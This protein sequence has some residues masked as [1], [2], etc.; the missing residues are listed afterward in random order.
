[1]ESSQKEIK[2]IVSEEDASIRI[3]K[4]LVKHIPGFSRTAFK[5]MIEK[6][7]VLVDS[8]AVNPHFNVAID[9]EISIKLPAPVSKIPQKEDIP[10]EAVFEND[11]F[12]IINKPAGMIVHPTEDGRHMEGTL[13]NALLNKYGAEGLSNLNGDLRPGIVHRLDKDTSGL[14]VVAKN[15]EIHEYLVDLFKNRNIE[16]TYTALVFGHL[17]PEDGT[18][19]SPIM[20]GKRNPTKMFL[21]P[22]D[23]GKHAVT[24]YHVDEHL[25]FEGHKLSLLAVQIQTGRTH[26]I[27]VHCNSI[28]YPVVGDPVYGNKKFNDAVMGDLGLK[29]QFLHA[30]QLKFVLSNGEEIVVK[31]K[32][33][34]DLKGVLDKLR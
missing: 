32:L 24:T 4:F 9:Q 22:E 15:N 14:I 28:G 10:L 3:D 34:N 30:T 12:A 21:A 33:P 13:V 31:T 26:Q 18:I 29:R 16:K 5:K 1:M 19:D 23:E 2:L 25:Q 27:R 20:R 17:N 8:K 11:D 7:D 6:G